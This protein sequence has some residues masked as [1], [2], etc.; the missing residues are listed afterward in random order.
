MS[1]KGMI[2]C[3]RYWTNH[4]YGHRWWQGCQIFRLT[5]DRNWW[6][7]LRGFIFIATFLWKEK[8]RIRY[9][10]LRSH[11]VIIFTNFPLWG[12]K[13]V[14]LNWRFIYNISDFNTYYT[15]SNVV[16]KKSLKVTWSI[17]ISDICTENTFIWIF[18]SLSCQRHEA[19]A[20]LHIRVLIQ[21]FVGY[22]MWRLQS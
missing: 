13:E 7:T 12:R 4:Q 19:E 15:V 17:S 8:E 1:I 18:H 16:I 9:N 11:T 21:S 10:L 2:S 3:R 6:L 5:W 22:L 14:N 20:S